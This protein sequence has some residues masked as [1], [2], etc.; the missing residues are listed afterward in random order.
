MTSFVITDAY[1]SNET[2]FVFTRRPGF[3]AAFNGWD[4]VVSFDHFPTR[5][6]VK[7]A[8]EEKYLKQDQYRVMTK[9]MRLLFK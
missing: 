1:Y 4:V 6:E 3:R 7:S 5:E 9:A 8:V 2:Y